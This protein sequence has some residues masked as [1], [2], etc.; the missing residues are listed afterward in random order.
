VAQT[1]ARQR[2][3]PLALTAT[4]DEIVAGIRSAIDPRRT[5]LAIIDLITSATARLL[6]VERIAAVLRDAGVPLLVDG[7]HAPGMLPLRIDALGADFFVGNL[8]KWAFAPRSTAI[9]TVAPEWRPAIRPLAVSWHQLEGF[10]ANVESSGTLD[11]TGWLAAPSGLFV[12]NSLGAERVRAH[13]AALARYAQQV[14]GAALGL[15][16]AQLPEPGGRLSMRLVPLPVELPATNAMAVGLRDRISDELAAEVAVNAWRGRLLLRLS[17]QV[18]NRP[19]EYDRL[20]AGLPDVLAR[21][22]GEH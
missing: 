12:L 18:Y 17:A 10:P 2:V 21:E 15:D 3:V 13:N 9:L 19:E 6:P 11:Y 14:V 5:R 1:G 4:D 16:G 8:H 20:A 7:A 22:I